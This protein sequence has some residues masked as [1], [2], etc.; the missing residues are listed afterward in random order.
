MRKIIR[1]VAF[2]LGLIESVNSP[3]NLT[4]LLAPYSPHCAATERLAA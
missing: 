3:E 2:R 4:A 1:R